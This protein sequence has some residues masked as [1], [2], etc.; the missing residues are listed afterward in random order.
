MSGALAGYG[1]EDEGS[2]A[3]SADDR[4]ERRRGSEEEVEDAAKVR[5]EMRKEKRYER[6]REMRMSNMGQEQRAKQLAR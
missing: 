4:E 6:E 3:S 1:S 2:E 5:D